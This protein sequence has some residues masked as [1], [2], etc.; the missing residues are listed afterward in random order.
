MTLRSALSSSYQDDLGQ[1]PAPDPGLEGAFRDQVHLHAE[2]TAEPILKLDETEEI[3]R[4]LE[5]HQE[6]EGAVWA[7]LVPSIGSKDANRLDLVSFA[8]RGQA[9]TESILDVVEIAFFADPAAAGK[10]SP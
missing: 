10:T 3:D 8:E 9:L 7:L 5:G 4:F 6:V 1:D 2:Q